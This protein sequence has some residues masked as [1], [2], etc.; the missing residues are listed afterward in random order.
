M[1]VVCAPAITIAAGVFVATAVACHGSTAVAATAGAIPAVVTLPTG[2][3]TPPLPLRCR[4]A[5]AAD[6][7]AAAVAF[8]LIVIVVAI[9][10][11]VSVAVAV[12]AFS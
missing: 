2:C 8:V 12:A 6:A 5:T 11:A 7:A 10:V 3:S 9:I 4:R 1:I